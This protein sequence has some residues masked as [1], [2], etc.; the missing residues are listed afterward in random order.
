MTDYSKEENHANV[1][2]FYKTQY[3]SISMLASGNTP[4]F[5][6][7]LLPA[8]ANTIRKKQDSDKMSSDLEGL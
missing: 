3:Q 4:A 7:K 6:K 1:A 2:K 5:T 8:D